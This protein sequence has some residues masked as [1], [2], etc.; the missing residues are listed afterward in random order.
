MTYNQPLA[1]E[2]FLATELAS[3]AKAEHLTPERHRKGESYF[4]ISGMQST[5]GIFRANVKFTISCYDERGALVS[6]QDFEKKCF[7]FNLSK[8]LQ[9]NIQSFRNRSHQHIPSL[10]Q[11]TSKV[12]ICLPR[13]ADLATR[14]HGDKSSKKDDDYLLCSGSNP[15]FGGTKTTTLKIDHQ[16]KNI[17]ASKSV[18]VTSSIELGDGKGRDLLTLLEGIKRSEYS[19]LSAAQ[20]AANQLNSSEN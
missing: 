4:S 2:L 13:F 17:E 5:G 11:K 19:V 6:S 20:E 18:S 3:A 16:D 10:I 14:N 1:R 7:R 15:K 8:T 12:E 9:E